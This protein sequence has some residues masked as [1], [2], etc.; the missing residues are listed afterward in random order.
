MLHLNVELQTI[1]VDYRGIIVDSRGMLVK[2][3][4]LGE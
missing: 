1:F 3:I 4:K 2:S